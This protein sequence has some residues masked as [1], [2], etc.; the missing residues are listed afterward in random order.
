[1]Q[2]QHQS[3]RSTSD[4]LHNENCYRFLSQLQF[5]E[6]QIAI[7]PELQDIYLKQYDPQYAYGNLYTQLISHID[8]QLTDAAQVLASSDWDSFFISFYKNNSQNLQ[9]N[10]INIRDITSDQSPTSPLLQHTIRRAIRDEPSTINRHTPAQLGSKLHTFVSMIHPIFKP[11]YFTNLPGERRYTYNQRLPNTELRIGTQ[12]QYEYYAPQ[13]S[14]IFKRFLFAQKRQARYFRPITHVYFNHLRKDYYPYRYQR[15]FE[16]NLTAV[17]HQLE[18]DHTNIAVITIPADQG[19]MSFHE[20]SNTEPHFDPSATE[21]LFLD[22]AREL[23]IAGW[24]PKDFHISPKIRKLVFGSPN[25][26]ERILRRLIQSSFKNMGLD[27]VE[28]L[29][30]AQ[31]QAVWVDFLKYEL[32]QHI[33]NTLQPDTC[34]FTCK[35]G[36]DRA[37]IASAY[38]NLMRSLKTQ[39]PMTR[40]EFEQA[41]HAA[42]LMVKGRGMN[43]HINILW[44]AVDLYIHVHQ[45]EFDDQTQWLIAWRD[46]NCPLER[47]GE[48]VERRLQETIH[49]LE[50]TAQSLIRDRALEVLTALRQCDRS[51]PKNHLLFLDVIV[52]TY[53]FCQKT[54]QQI[55][56]KDLQHYELLIEKMLDCDERPVSWMETFLQ[57]L[58]YLFCLKQPAKIHGEEFGSLIAKMSVWRTISLKLP[59][60]EDKLNEERLGY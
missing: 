60:I 12:A 20:I 10:Y 52:S 44:N 28:Q 19:L 46:A 58:R 43:E 21:R 5:S 55:K 45:H 51:Y 14:P 42:P 17:L 53:A 35:D 26:E 32:P 56:Q 1:M 59:K 6:V 41:L 48:L 7:L 16:S 31:R 54:S 23:P 40:Q 37:G 30:P 22:I 13:V 27:G 25:S 50:Y 4:Q 3:M 34:N 33:L 29:S 47:A 36:I 39:Y 49:A 18:N 38:Y 8:R 2:T 24:M 57:F 9:K 11:T 15:W